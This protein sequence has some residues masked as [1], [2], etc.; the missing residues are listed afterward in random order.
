MKKEKNTEIC[1]C[2]DPKPHIIWKRESF[3]NITVV[4][5]SDGDV[6]S[7]FEIRNRNPLNRK[8]LWYIA[9]NTC[10][11]N[12]KDLNTLIKLARKLK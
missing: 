5:W 4:G 12:Y 6:G 2:G 7:I 3:D 1:S 11:Y 10:L 9:E 8:Q